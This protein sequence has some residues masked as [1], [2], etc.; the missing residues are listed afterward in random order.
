MS[1]QGDEML[2]WVSLSILLN[3]G[4]DFDLREIVSFDIARAVFEEWQ[5]VWE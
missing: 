5:K 1:C 2:G 3:K 4:K